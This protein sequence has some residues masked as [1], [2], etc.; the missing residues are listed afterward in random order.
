[1]LNMIY[2]YDYEKLQRR[3]RHSLCK[4]GKEFA[5]AANTLYK[6]S[7]DQH[8]HPSWP[9]HFVTC[10]ALELYLKAFLRAN[11]ASLDELRD[12]R[13]LGHDLQRILCEAKQKGLDKVVAITGDE[14]HIIKILNA[15]YKNRDF[16]YKNAGEFT[17]ADVGGL[18]PLLGRIDSPLLA[19]CAGA[20]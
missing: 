7:Q 16:Q 15:H 1:M 19:M 17:L 14:E 6:A 2:T 3:C 8:V 5:D 9:I 18:I 13:K 11:G 20:N 12:R 10:Q 4:T